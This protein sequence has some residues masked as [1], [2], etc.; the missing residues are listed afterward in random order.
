MMGSARMNSVRAVFP[1]LC[2]IARQHYVIEC[3]DLTQA[4]FVFLHFVVNG[5]ATGERDSCLPQA[6]PLLCN[7]NEFDRE[8]TPPWL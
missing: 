6:D 8:G 4:W 5:A 1:V 2:C 3:S 7:P